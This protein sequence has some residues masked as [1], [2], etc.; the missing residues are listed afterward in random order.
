[1]TAFLTQRERKRLDEPV[2]RTEKHS[3]S[4]GGG[5]VFPIAGQPVNLGVQGY[6]NPVRPDNVPDASLRI[7]LT[8]LF[9]R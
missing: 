5:R 4:G 2:R 7:V 8:F 1:M 3:N 6:W 9:P